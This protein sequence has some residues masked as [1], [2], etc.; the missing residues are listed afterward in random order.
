MI[1]AVFFDIDDTLV[2]HTYGGIPEGTK[3]AV[4]KLKA[5]GIKV[6]AA[7]GRNLEEIESLPV[8]D[9]AFDGYVTLNGQICLDENKKMI[10]GNAIDEE[11]VR[12]MTALFREKTL[13][14]II[15]EESRM[16][17]NFVNEKVIETQKAI[18]ARPSKIGEYHGGK[19]YQFITYANDEQIRMLQEMLPHC[20]MTRWGPEGIDIIAQ[21]G[22]KVSG[23]QQMLQYY[24]IAPDEIMAFGDGENDI[25]MMKYA[26]IGIAMG[27]AENEVKANADYVTNHIDDDG[28]RKALMHYKE[29]FR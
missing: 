20:K 5:Q 9:V 25:D 24:G 21:N 23:I 29:V 27:N 22:G 28:I 2:S 1:K 11:D 10:Y 12:T 3:E 6:F 4:A 19:V 8:E 7:T 15:V 17:I 16:Y 14:T 18:S 26:H 13:P